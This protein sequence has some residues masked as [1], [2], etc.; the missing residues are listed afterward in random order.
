MSTVTSYTPKKLLHIF[1]FLTT[2]SIS[3][4]HKNNQSINRLFTQKLV[5]H[6]MKYIIRYTHTNF[7]TC[8]LFTFM[9]KVCGG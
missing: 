8:I 3:T 2:Y 1:S 6:F 7:T 9:N 4:P 5:T